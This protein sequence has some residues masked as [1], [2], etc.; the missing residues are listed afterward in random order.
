MPRVGEPEFG[1]VLG[2]Q[3]LRMNLDAFCNIKLH[4]LNAFAMLE[5][6]IIC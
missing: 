2:S 3:G 6:E 1:V 5:Y 4:Y